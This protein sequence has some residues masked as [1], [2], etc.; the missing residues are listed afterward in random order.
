MPLHRRGT[1]KARTPELDANVGQRVA[2]SGVWAALTGLVGIPFV[3]V[4]TVAL[5]RIL[6]ASGYGRFAFYTFVL[7][8]AEGLLDLGVSHT[9]LQ[10]ASAA[11]GRSEVE[12]VV[13]ICRGALSW[14]LGRA[15]ILSGLGLLV[16]DDR[17]AWLLYSLGVFVGCFAV[18]SSFYL[19]V[20]S[21]IRG[22]TQIRLLGAILTAA[23]AIPVAATTR[24]PALTFA[25]SWCATALPTVLHLCYISSDRRRQLIVPGRIDVAKGDPFVSLA[26]FFNTQLNQFVFSRSEILFFR[27]GQGVAR[28]AYSAAQT[29]AVRSTIVLDALFSSVDAGLSTMWG[30]GQDELA[31]AWSRLIRITS[32]L[33]MLAAPAVLALVV[34]VAVPAFGSS[35]EGILVPA[36]LMSAV[37]LLQT[38][39]IPFTALLFAERSPARLLVVGVGATLLDV[40]LAATLVPRVGLSGAVTANVAAGLFYVSAMGALIAR[41]RP[42][43]AQVLRHGAAMVVT[44][45]LATA[46]A[47][48]LAALVESSIARAAVILLVECSGAL[49]L[50]RVL[51]PV[52]AGDVRWLLG[53][54]PG[55]SWIAQRPRWLR[56][57]LDVD[58]GV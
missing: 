13:G 37:A 47:L 34:G 4:T 11:L 44:V 23:V 2:R 30:R 41:R 17:A 15:P 21:D 26:F 12:A 3:L 51:R 46:V 29:I 6:Q 8:F 35:Y 38:S 57:L 20:T 9:L 31:A 56:R 32:L 1:R 43:R 49:V 48:G 16:L 45:V 7:T 5:A 24:N 18:G 27:P 19:T 55:G 14:T 40:G 52:D 53:R 58:I 50:V 25:V 28:G 54:L 39:A 36:A 22:L 10:R 33:M 42:V